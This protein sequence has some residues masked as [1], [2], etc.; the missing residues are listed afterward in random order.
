[1]YHESNKGLW[2]YL[3]NRRLNHLQLMLSQNSQMKSLGNVW[4][5]VGAV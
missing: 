1:M 2:Q 4:S 3:Q 5:I